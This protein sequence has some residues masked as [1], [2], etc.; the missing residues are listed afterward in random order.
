MDS[1]EQN[2]GE[3]QE[4]AVMTS[5]PSCATNNDNNSINS[6]NPNDSSSQ[7]SRNSRAEQQ[8]PHV[9][10]S[11]CDVDPMELK[12]YSQIRASTSLEANH[13]NNNSANNLNAIHSGNSSSGEK[14]RDNKKDY[15]KDYK[16]K[17][18][19][20]DTIKQYSIDSKNDDRLEFPGYAPVIFKYFSQK[21]LPRYW[22]LKIIT[23]PW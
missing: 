18:S 13:N 4:L 21:S 12:E 9:T 16:R 19:L 17:Q 10:P 15:K 11:V 3:I 2:S 20:I 14:V 7:Y 5:R 1:P 22:F 8:Q 6:D 23:K